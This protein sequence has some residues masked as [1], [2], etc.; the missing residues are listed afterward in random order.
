LW[1]LTNGSHLRYY[2]AKSGRLTRVIESPDR[3]AIAAAGRPAGAAWIPPVKL[4]VYAQII[5]I[6]LAPDHRS[7]LVEIDN[8]VECRR[9]DFSEPG[10]SI[11]WT[12]PA[13]TSPFHDPDTK[14][15]WFWSPDASKLARVGGG[16]LTI[17][18]AASGREIHTF[19]ALVSTSRKGAWSPDS[20]KFAVLDS[21]DSALTYGVGAPFEIDW[22]P[23]VP[24]AN[25][26]SAK[27]E[28][29]SEL[30]MR[31][32]N[33]SGLITTPDNAWALQSNA[34]RATVRLLSRSR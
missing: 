16:R 13:G 3:F 32:P 27:L 23:V 20:K 7:L 4:P 5:P 28:W 11:L 31:E 2:D 14:V 12:L 22:M 15:D 9:L 8:K 33:A 26:L 34:T 17:L 6:A 24:A 30:A 25:G 10:N 19:A 1:V 29:T 21:A 18:D